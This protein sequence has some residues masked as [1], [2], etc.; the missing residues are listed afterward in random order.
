MRMRLIFTSGDPSSRN[1]SNALVELSAI[2]SRGRFVVKSDTAA[3]RSLV[4]SRPVSRT[5]SS[6]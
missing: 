2:R 6:T 4:K 5:D 1:S 3:E